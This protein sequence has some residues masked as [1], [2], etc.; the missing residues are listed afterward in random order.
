MHFRDLRWLF[1]LVLLC[2]CD[3]EAEVRSDTQPVKASQD[4]G[5]QS[6]V[7][8]R[9]WVGIAWHSL[10][11]FD[12]SGSPACVGLPEVE[13]ADAAIFDFARTADGRLWIPSSGMDFSRPEVI[14][15]DP[16]TPELRS[17][18]SG[19]TTGTGPIVPSRY[20]STLPW[21]TSG[22]MCCASTR[23]MKRF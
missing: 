10:C 4:E 6:V 3:T 9:R 11:I 5:Y 1:L 14:E 16:R 19:S 13:S 8:G 21:M 18:L 22:C 12:R 15:L 23:C 20:R 17:G 7:G 2:A